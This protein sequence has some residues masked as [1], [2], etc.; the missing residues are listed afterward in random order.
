[1]RLLVRK[2]IKDPQ[3]DKVI[4]ESQMYEEVNQYTVNSTNLIITCRDNQ[5]WEE[6]VTVR[7]S[8][9][10]IGGCLEVITKELD[11]EEEKGPGII[12]PS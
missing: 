11:D 3:M 2:L 10:P 12:L 7:T 9:I 5:P 4:E 8:I 1:M 6:K